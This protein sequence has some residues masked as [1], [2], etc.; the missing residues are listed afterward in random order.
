LPGFGIKIGHQMAVVP[1]RLLK[2]PKVMYS[3]GAQQVDEER[4][5]W[6]LRSVRFAKGMT[7]DLSQFAVLIIKDGGRT[8]FSLSD[9]ELATTVQGFMDMCQKCG[10]RVQGGKAMGYIQ[11]NLPPKG[12]EDPTRKAAIN[13]IR[14]TIMTL[15]R[16]PKI[17]LV[18]L[19]NGDKHIYA[20]IKHLCDVWLDVHTVC[21][22]SDKI[23]RQAGQLQYFANVALKFNMK[24]GG[25][26]HNLDQEAMTWLKQEP[27]MLVGMD[28]THPGPG[29]LKGTPSIAAIVAS[30]DDELAQFP[31]SLR[32]QETKKEMITGLKDMMKERLESYQKSRNSLPK[33]IVVYRDGVSEGQYATVLREEM[34][35]MKEAFRKFD[36][37]SRPYRP[38]LTIVICGKRHNTRF[39]PVEKSAADPNL[40]N[41]KPGTVV[42]KGVTG[43]YAF[44]FFLQAHG[45]LQ[46][47]TRPTHYFVVH[48]ENR[49]T[50]DAIQ[51]V[52][53]D[54]SYLFA[55]ATKAVSLVS[56]AY[57]A[58][59]ACER[60]RCYIHELL[61]AV[62]NST[63]TSQSS[64]E[65]QVM[66]SAETLWRNGVRGNNLKDS[67][68]YL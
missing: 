15:P 32:I 28:V 40:G 42:D 58:D 33:R 59:L 19:S 10:M 5:S 45:G 36:T 66:R 22:H 55:R 60:G 9:P 1:G 8:E 48:D 67:M 63:T 24:L 62:E 12:R 16:P 25:V 18:M 21:V 29:S 26:N 56:P 43:I 46:G 2:A 20:G 11:A 61:M 7:I 17:M 50:A 6:N 14:S 44:D 38:T 49:F 47:T 51:K 53:H 27:T 23:R 54:V 64:A 68:F 30:V 65:D 34:P 41:P 3:R 4:A 13:A 37:G 35:E 31:A 39:Y 57:Y 52:T